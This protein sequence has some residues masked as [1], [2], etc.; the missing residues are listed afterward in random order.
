MLSVV[1]FV[2]VAGLGV[3]ALTR[4]RIF[5]V[6][7]FYSFYTLLTVLDPGYVPRIGPIT[8]YRALYLIAFLSLVARLIQ[9]SNFLSQMRRWPLA[10]YFFL[11][12]L[13]MASSLYSQ[14]TQT[15]LSPERQTVWDIIAI[16][17]LFWLA[18]A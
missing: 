8:L 6:S 4:H 17:S 9:D 14:T 18:A 16:S 5:I 7:G 13:I 3:L 1:L 15:F 2:A 11:L 10:S 12:V